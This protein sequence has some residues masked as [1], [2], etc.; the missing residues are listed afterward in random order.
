MS[1]MMRIALLVLVVFLSTLSTTA[2]AALSGAE[3]DRI[4]TTIEN[5]ITTASD[6]HDAGK[7]VAGT[8][9]VAKVTDKVSLAFSKEHFDADLAKALKVYNNLVAHRTKLNSSKTVNANIKSAPTRKEPTGRLGNLMRAEQKTNRLQPK[10]GKVPVQNYDVYQDYQKNH[11]AKINAENRA[12]EVDMQRVIAERRSAENELLQRKQ[13]KQQIQAQAMKWQGELDRQASASS[14]AAA[15]WE[16]EHSFGAYA[17]RFLGSVLQTTVG[18]FT[19]ALLTPITANMANQ[20]VA[21]LFPNAPAGNIATQAGATATQAAGS[22]VAGNAGTAA[23]QAAGS[24]VSGQGGATPPVNP[25]D[26]YVPGF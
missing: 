11:M 21:Q 15:K 26:I 1:K 5:A 7:I 13:R 17:R 24:A 22:S 12:A 23:G 6:R 20:A 16:Q 14:R 19:T 2:F 25:D 8:P 4:I 18:S 10:A 3:L 9:Y